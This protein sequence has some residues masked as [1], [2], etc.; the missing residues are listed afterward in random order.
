MAFAEHIRELRQR[1]RYSVIAL[2]AGF[3]VSLK[4][5]EEIFV[6]LA[7]PLLT[8]WET[9]QPDNEALGDSSFYFAGLIDPFWT[10]FSLAFWAGIFVSSPVIF[11]QLWKF[12]APGL[13]KK[14]RLWG[15]VFAMVSALLFAG[16]AL[17][18]YTMVLPAVCEFLLN[19]ATNSL[20]VGDSQVG[21]RPLL[22]MREY[23]DFAKKLLIGFGLIFELPLVITVM[24][25]AGLVTHRSLWKFNRWATLLAFLVAAALTPPDIYS[26]L[27]MAG[28][29]IVLYNISIILAFFIT[30][31]KERKARA[32]ASDDNDNDNDNDN[33]S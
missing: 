30:I 7:Q 18:C 3:A 14:E 29:L 8:R 20:S 17:F 10:Y 22:G 28:P 26:Q 11:Y 19:Y 24:A 2:A 4:F 6:L 33:G 15:I 9:M 32:L 13:Y 23:L 21:L 27:F 31:A 1:L 16:G 5:S 25:F 12:I